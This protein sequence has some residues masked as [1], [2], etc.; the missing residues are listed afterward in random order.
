MNI[1][2]I[3]LLAVAL[4]AIY[5]GVRDGLLVQIG[6]VVGLVVGA[7]L[8]FRYAER[9]GIWF[10]MNG[11]EASVA[12]FI[13][14]LVVSVIVITLGSRLLRGVFRWTG[15]GIFDSL[16]GAALSVLKM[17]VI[18]SLV[19][20]AIDTLNVNYS[21]IGR[22]KI[23]SSKAYLPLRNFSTKIFPLFERVKEQVMGLG[24]SADE[25]LNEVEQSAASAQ[26][27]PAVEEPTVAND[28]PEN[29]TEQSAEDDA[30]ESVKSKIE[31]QI[32]EKVKEVIIEKIEN[33]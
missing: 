28:T 30:A 7:W 12:G 1:I 21:L 11:A 18:A 2:D 14:V 32:G 8:A 20:A 6:G 3:I 4:W 17:A 13:A 23:E 9:V 29:I 16:F 26:E 5:D 25:A 33:I 10:G 31:K 22:E 24:K 27:E 19:I 15:L